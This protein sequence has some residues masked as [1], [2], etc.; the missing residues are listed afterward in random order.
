MRLPV[1]L[2]ATLL[3]MDARM[4]IEINMDVEAIDDGPQAEDLDKEEH[5]EDE[6]SDDLNDLTDSEDSEDM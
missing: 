6:Y 4:S 2:T 5:E 1:L 3:V